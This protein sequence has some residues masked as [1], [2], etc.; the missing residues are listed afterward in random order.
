VFVLPRL[1]VAVPQGNSGSG[2]DGQLGLGTDADQLLP[3]L[4]G[5]ADEVFDGE[6]VVM[7]AA[8]RSGFTQWQ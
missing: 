4:V 6:A 7:V 2:A 5:G 1:P 8:E 3:V